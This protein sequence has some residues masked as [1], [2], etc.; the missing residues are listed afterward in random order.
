MNDCDITC[1]LYMILCAGAILAAFLRA[2]YWA[3]DKLIPTMII[4]E[5]IGGNDDDGTEES[6]D[7]GK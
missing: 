7:K 1:K 3:V 4:I 2:A 5:I 6:E